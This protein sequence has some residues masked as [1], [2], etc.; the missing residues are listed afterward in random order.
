MY[1][2]EA[3]HPAN[4]SLNYD[5]DS[6]GRASFGLPSRMGRQSLG[7]SW[8]RHERRGTYDNRHQQVTRLA[9]PH[10]AFNDHRDP[11]R[12]TATNTH[13]RTI[14]IRDHTA[15]FPEVEVMSI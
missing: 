7:Q 6:I 5:N 2:G 15:D 1:E 8:N 12:M 13:K 10:S 3:M 14:D 9:S 4:I 11:S